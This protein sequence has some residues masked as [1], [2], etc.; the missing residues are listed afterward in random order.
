MNIFYEP[1][2]RTVEIHGSPYRIVTD[3]REWIKF[4]DLVQDETIPMAEKGNMLLQWYVD[5]PPLEKSAVYALQKFLIAKELYPPIEEINQ[6][7]DEEEEAEQDVVP[8]FSYAVD[9]SSIFCAF[10]SCYH[11]DLE[12]VSYLHWWKFKILFDGLPEDTEIKQ[13]IYYRTLDL[14]TI[15]DKDEKKRIRNIQRKIS[16]QK[17][18][19]PDDFEIG[20]MF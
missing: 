1:F 5:V 7:D 4:M 11:I 18:R 2:P 9:A 15:K 16:L 19:L 8:A 20:G 17:K 3:F 12:K 10:M 13:R 6:E 14:S